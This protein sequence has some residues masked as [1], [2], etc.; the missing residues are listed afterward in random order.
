MRKKATALLLCLQKSFSAQLSLNQI[1]QFFGRRA[2]GMIMT[3]ICQN[4]Q[5]IVPAGNQ[6]VMKL[7]SIR[8]GFD[9]KIHA[10]LTVKLMFHSHIQ[11]FA[12]QF[13][14]DFEFLKNLLGCVLYKENPLGLGVLR[15]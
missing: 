13:Q 4:F 12:A 8:F 2:N 6:L 3:I 1:Q 5:G 9:Q 15:L 10:D 14:N 7:F 11:N